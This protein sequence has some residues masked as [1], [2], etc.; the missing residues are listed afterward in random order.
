MSLLVEVCVEGVRGAVSAAEG[1]ADRVELCEALEVDGLTPRPEVMAEASRRL[2]IPVQVLI[3][4][5][6]GGFVYDPID[7]EKMKRALAIAKSTGAAGVVIGANRLDGTVDRDAIAVLVALARPLSVTFHKAFDATTDPFTALDDLIA[8][9]VDRVLTSG[10]APT[11][12]E[13]L[14]LLAGLTR[15][16]AGR[17]TILAGG[18]VREADLPTLASAGIKEVHGASAVMTDGETDPIKVR[19]LVLAA[20]RASSG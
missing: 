11:A 12:R 15:R 1:G 6:A 8:I 20:R 4:P 14:S 3:R 7:F 18:R 5:R 10:Q 2:S 13:G 16:S 17:I 9:G 19:S